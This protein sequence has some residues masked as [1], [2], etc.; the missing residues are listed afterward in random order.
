VADLSV[1]MLL[2]PPFESDPPVKFNI[3]AKT[4][5]LVYAILA[6][7]GALFGLVGVFATFGLSALGAALGVTQIFILVVAGAVIGEIGTI[8]VAWGGYQMY[9]DK[10]EGKRMAILGL[11]VRVLGGLVAAVGGLNPFGL[12]AWIVGTAVTFCFYYLVVISRFPGE[13]PLVASGGM[14]G[15]TPPPPGGMPGGNPPPPA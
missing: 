5:G 4:L 2:H 14:T 11:A 12:F 13:Q 9:Q 8:M 1:D 6:G 10:P 15:G 7:I 3:N